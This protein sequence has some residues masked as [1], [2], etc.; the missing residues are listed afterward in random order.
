VNGACKKSCCWTPY[1]HS[2]AR[3][4][5]PDTDPRA[6]R[7][8]APASRDVYALLKGSRHE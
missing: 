3:D 4:H 5:L 2:T 6:C 1:Q 7:C 8:H